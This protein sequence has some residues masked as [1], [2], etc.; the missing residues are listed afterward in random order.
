MISPPIVCA[1]IGQKMLSVC[2]ARRL[3]TFP[4]AAAPMI[5]RRRSRWPRPPDLPRLT[6]IANTHGDMLGK[7][8][9]PGNRPCF[10]SELAPDWAGWS[11]VG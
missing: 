11:S 9:A 5:S 8:E 1:T 6:W 7:R 4:S 3:C 10:P 2:F